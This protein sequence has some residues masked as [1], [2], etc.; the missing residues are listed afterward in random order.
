MAFVQAPLTVGVL[1]AVYC[2][3]RRRRM[4]KTQVPY[5]VHT[6]LRAVPS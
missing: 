6:L 5:R 4:E 3:Q 2:A 1:G